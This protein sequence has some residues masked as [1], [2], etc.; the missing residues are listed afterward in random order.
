MSIQRTK[1]KAFTLVELLVVIAVIALLVAVLLP[2][3]GQAREAARD[4]ICRSNMRQVGF[5]SRRS[6]SYTV[7]CDFMVSKL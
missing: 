4:A 5:S 6:G 3:L 7:E 1:R 2:A